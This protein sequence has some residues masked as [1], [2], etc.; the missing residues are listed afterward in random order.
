M[1][2]SPQNCKS[3]TTATMTPLGAGASSRNII[4]SLEAGSEHCVQLMLVQL[5]SAHTVSLA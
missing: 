1:C 5:V 4:Q 2:L 3:H